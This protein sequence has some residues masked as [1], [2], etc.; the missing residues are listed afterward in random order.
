M[1]NECHCLILRLLLRGHI[2]D[3]VVV[4][5][6]GDSDFGCL[7]RHRWDVE[8]EVAD[9]LVIDCL[10]LLSLVDLELENCLVLS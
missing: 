10:F 8:F 3:A 9:N 5:F 6:E 2:Q 4:N 1:N 7:D